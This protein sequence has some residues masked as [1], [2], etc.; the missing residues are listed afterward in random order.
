MIS[1]A[2]GKSLWFQFKQLRC[3]SLLSHPYTQPVKP[4]TKFHN[5]V[6]VV[7]AN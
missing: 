2:V 7:S 4:A 6:M 5:Y 3:H 1:Q